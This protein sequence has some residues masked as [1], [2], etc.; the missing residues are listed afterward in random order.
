MIVVVMPQ[1]G[2]TITEAVLLRWHRQAGELVEA[3]TALFEIETE[4][5][6]MDI[7]SVATGLL[8]DVAVEEGATV[9]VGTRLANLIPVRPRRVQEGTLTSQLSPAVRRLLQEHSLRE[10]QVSGTG[11]QGRITKRDVLALLA[12]RS[13]GQQEN[14][15]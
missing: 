11:P 3:G 7:D 13:S 15:S 1:P 6:T 5:A 9:A 10:S 12:A 8:A 2:E 4:K 14:G